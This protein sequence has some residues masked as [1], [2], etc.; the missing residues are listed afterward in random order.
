MEPGVM[1]PMGDRFKLIVKNVTGEVS[2]VR[3]CGLIE[4]ITS[5]VRLDSHDFGQHYSWH[6]FQFVNH[7]SHAC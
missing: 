6:C 7:T 2:V 1:E 4:P 3:M 5:W